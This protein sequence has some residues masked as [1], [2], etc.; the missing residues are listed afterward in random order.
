[1]GFY[2]WRVKYMVKK[3]SFAAATLIWAAAAAVIIAADRIIKHIVM[4]NYSEG[5]RIGE[6]PGFFDFIYVRNT[7]AAFSLFSDMTLILGIVSILFC[8]CAAVYWFVKK[9]DRAMKQAAVALLFAGALGNAVDRIF[10]GYV[11]DF[12]S[13]KWFDFPVFNIA[14]AAIVAGAVTAVVYV[15]FFDREKKGSLDEQRGEN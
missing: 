3:K 7:G 14:D 10:Y 1:M 4:T 5:S 9:P 8:I 13:I 2:L 12:I 15:V 11:V 6:L